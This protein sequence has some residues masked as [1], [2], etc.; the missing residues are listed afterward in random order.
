M[1]DAAEI[2][3][4]LKIVG[5]SVKRTEDPRLLTGLGSYTD[6]RQVARTLHVAFRRSDQ[7]HARI[8]AIDC[9]AAR[10]APGVLAVFTA[11]D[12][13][14]IKPLVASSRMANYYATPILPLASGKVRYVGEPVIGVIAES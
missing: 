2:S 8:C 10:A 11:E 1:T 14:D 13:S 5:A 4:G 7:S 6:D 3:V 9:N 12:L